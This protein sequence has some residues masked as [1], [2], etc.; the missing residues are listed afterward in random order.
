M[1]SRV[2]QAFWQ[3][4]AFT[5]SRVIQGNGRTMSILLKM[6][7][8][9]R[10]MFGVV[11]RSAVGSP[12]MFLIV[13]YSFMAFLAILCAIF[14]DALR[15]LVGFPPDM[16]H[17]QGPLENYLCGILFVLCY[18]IVRVVLFLLKLLGIEDESDFP[19]IEADWKEILTAF[20]RE[21]IYIDDLPLFLVNGFTPQQEQSAFEA[22]SNIEWRVIAPPLSQTSAVVRAFARED[23]IFVCCTGIGATNCQQGKVVDVTDGNSSD[24]GMLRAGVFRPGGGVTGTRRAEE[25]PEVIPNT[26]SATGTIRSMNSA[27]A[28]SMVS[29]PRGM[30]AFFGTM[31]PGGL[32]R[33][34]ESFSAINRGSQ[35]GYGKKRVMPLSEVESLVGIR[36]MQFLCGLIAKARAPFCQINGM[37]QAVPFSWAAEVEYARKLAPAIKDDLIAVHETFQL[38][39]PVVA[40]VTEVDSVSGMRDFLLRAER[41]QPGLR[42]SRSGSSFAPGAEVNDKNAAWI[43]DRG[44]QWFRG[45]VYTAFS[46][47]IDNR[48]NQK[49]F[50]MLCE[51]SQRRQG[52][53]TLLR[54]SL[55]R[56]VQPSPRL[57][58][59]YFSATGRASTEQGFIRG[60]LDKLP[61]SQGMV[62]WTPQLVRSQQ[63]SKLFSICFFTAAVLVSGM[64]VAVYLY[65]IAGAT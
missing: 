56:I 59:V 35:K 20:S 13:H 50:Q 4:S 62:A 65:R 48:D 9:V 26:R 49:L 61:E 14:S 43:V 37:L 63:R 5:S 16:E 31:T 55:Y 46:S 54:D 1:Q 18:A 33:A 52:L 45:W 19:D 57:H 15:T 10:W 25:L 11:P 38:Q 12:R 29:T 47:D 53:I 39:F 3:I 42:L 6:M 40:V 51:I 7:E 41:M 2:P 23:A 64:A 17:L 32:K 36:R 22:A 27:G 60:V 58:G 44:L 8:W 21:R 34:M 28:E 30:G 24:S